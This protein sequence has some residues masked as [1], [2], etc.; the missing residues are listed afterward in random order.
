MA[1]F[2]RGA[3]ESPPTRDSP[4]RTERPLAAAFTSLCF[5]AGRP[6]VV[7]RPPSLG[8]VHRIN[9]RSPQTDPVGLVDAAGHRLAAYSVRWPASCGPMQAPSGLLQRWV[10]RTRWRSARLG[11]PSACNLC[12]LALTPSPKALTRSAVVLS[13]SLSMR[14]RFKTA[15]YASSTRAE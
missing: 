8:A 7:N 10:Q 13:F 12:T 4:R 5:C 3:G 2:C 6:G 11:R 14:S 9:R 15:L 1:P